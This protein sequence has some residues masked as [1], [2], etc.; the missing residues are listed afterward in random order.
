MVL[1]RHFC[2]WWITALDHLLQLLTDLFRGHRSHD[3]YETDSGWREDGPSNTIQ[4]IS[5]VAK[6]CRNWF[7]WGIIKLYNHKKTSLKV[8]L[9]VNQEYHGGCGTAQ[10][11]SSKVIK[12]A[13]S[14]SWIWTS[15]MREEQNNRACL[16]MELPW[17]SLNIWNKK[18][19]TLSSTKTRVAV[20]SLMAREVVKVFGICSTLSIRWRPR[21]LQQSRPRATFQ[22]PK[23]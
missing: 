22:I 16:S 8:A 12:S 20:D 3:T 23:P 19:Q 21:E 14:H 10:L 9:V 7:Q 4:L 17:Y 2:Q 15:R 13:L 6:S 18:I 11:S 5:V 1:P